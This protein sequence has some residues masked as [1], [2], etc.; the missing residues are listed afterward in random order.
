MTSCVVTWGNN[1][2]TNDSII[3]ADRKLHFVCY[4]GF[5]RFFRYLVASDCVYIYGGEQVRGKYRGHGRNLLSNMIISFNV[6]ARNCWTRWRSSRLEFKVTATFFNHFN[7]IIVQLPFDN[8]AIAV[9]TRQGRF[10]EM[11]VP[12]GLKVWIWVH[13][14]RAKFRPHFNP[15]DQQDC[16]GSERLYL[17]RLPVGTYNL[18]NSGYESFEL[19]LISVTLPQ[20]PV[21]VKLLFRTLWENLIYIRLPY[22]WIWDTCNW[23]MGTCWRNFGR[24]ASMRFTLTQVGS[25]YYGGELWTLEPSRVISRLPFAATIGSAW[26]SIAS[27]TW[28]TSWTR[29]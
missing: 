11:M 26:E 29:N 18:N 16:I 19:G 7:T 9:L 17:F 15:S 5:W 1:P 8:L 28:M 3:P 21:H 6:L 10:V 2:G 25:V 4:R 24:D 12:L 13:D 23:G 14:S 20:L 27:Q 22:A